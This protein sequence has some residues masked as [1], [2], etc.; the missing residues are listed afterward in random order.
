MGFLAFINGPWGALAEK[1]LLV[2]LVVG[3]IIF[4]YKD[5]SGTASREQA[6]KDQNAQI[7]QLQ[8]DEQNLQQTLGIIQKDNNDI[9]VKLDKQNQQVITDHDV[10]THY[11]ESPQGQQSNQQPVAPVISNTIGMLYNDQ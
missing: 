8:K 2:L 1:A 10:I 11:I 3:S 6:L 7:V 5:I 4:V 9:L